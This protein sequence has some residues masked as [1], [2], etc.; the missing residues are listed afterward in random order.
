MS[1]I[2]SA[3]LLAMLPTAQ[4]GI[5][6]LCLLN[7]RLQPQI[8]LLPLCL[9]SAF[10]ALTVTLSS[11]TDSCK[12]TLAQ[13]LGETSLDKTDFPKQKGVSTSPSPF[14][15]PQ[16]LSLCLIPALCASGAKIHDL[17]QANADHPFALLKNY[18]SKSFVALLPPKSESSHFHFSSLLDK[19]S[20]CK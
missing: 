13:R 2:V 6:K 16:L 7:S 9:L 18:T 3:S 11:E 1:A 12:P 20:L 10:L 5:K 14:A 8:Q 15:F 19:G 4:W 17:P